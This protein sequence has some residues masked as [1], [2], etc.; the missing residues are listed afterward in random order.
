MHP[1]QRDHLETVLGSIVGSTQKSLELLR[2]ASKESS[3]DKKYE[4]SQRPAA[5]VS[6]PSTTVLSEDCHH[7]SFWM[8]ER[9]RLESEVRHL[10]NKVA[11]EEDAHI[12][13][14]VVLEREMGSLREELGA[15]FD[16][17]KQARA[18]SEAIAGDLGRAIKANKIL[19][20]RAEEAE[21][22]LKVKE[23]DL[24]M[25]CQRDSE[26]LVDCKRKLEIQEGCLHA[27]EAE[28]AALKR[29]GLLCAKEY[30]RGIASLQEEVRKDR[31]THQGDY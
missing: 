24:Q 3:A 4:Y 8:D 1:L 16:E 2:C 20:Q 15:S 23:G 25:Q 10:K 28:I 12:S 11:V 26:A 31:A 14:V 27:A 13:K 6:S 17:L 30:Q 5:T 18:C 21:L 29:N 9:E 7:S 19:Q 22:L